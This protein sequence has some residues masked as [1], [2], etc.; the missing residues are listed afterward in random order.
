MRD[1]FEVVQVDIR[2]GIWGYSYLW[3]NDE[4]A[5]VQRYFPTY[6][7]DCIFYAGYICVSGIAFYFLRNRLIGHLQNVYGLKHTS[8]KVTSK[9]LFLL[10]VLLILL[11]VFYT[12]TLIV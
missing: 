8:A 1:F 12:I 10:V 7:W 6:I 4:T 3:P 9:I 5:S 11:Q 2:D